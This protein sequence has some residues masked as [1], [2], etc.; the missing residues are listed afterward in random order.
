MI[1]KTIN[2]V[3]ISS[4]LIL[5]NAPIY[6]QAVYHHVQHTGIYEFLD[7]MGTLHLID[8]HTAIKPYTRKTIAEKLAV[9]NDKKDSLNARQQ[10]ELAFYLKDFNKELK[11]GKNFNKRIDLFYY[12]DSLFTFSVNPIL[13]SKAYYNANKLV[14]HWWNGAEAFAY[15]DDHWGF[16]ASLRD[17]H[18]SEQLYRKQD[19]LSKQIGG[20]NYKN[21]DLGK[22]FEEMRGGVTYAWKWGTLG[23]VKDQFVWGN[24]YNGSN[25]FSGTTPSF[26]HIKLHLTPAKWF[27]FRYVHAWLISESLDSL[28]SYYF[29]TGPEI[30]YRGIYY[31]KYMAANMFT[32][33]PINGLNLS[34]G[35]SIIYSD[36][37][38]HPAY[39]V[40]IFFYKAVDHTLNAGTDNMNSQMFFDISTRNV[41]H[42]HLYS[43]LFID[44]ISINRM[45]IDSSHSNFIS[46]KA[47][48]HITGLLPNTFFTVEY[49]KTNPLTYKHYIETLT[50]ESNRFNMG[51]YLTDNARE[52]Y[53]DASWKP[54]NTLKI[55]TFYSAAIKGTNYDRKTS[56]RDRWGLPFINETKWKNNTIGLSTRYEIIN[57]AYISAAFTRSIISGE[58]LNQYTPECF[59]GIKNTVSLGLNYGF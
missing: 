12:K 46:I 4:L 14:Y 51:H 56:A 24:N 16:Y 45:F 25:I 47:G 41:E 20:A 52:L 23:L 42:L 28:R 5:I 49:T 30:R 39:L 32:F 44:E 13:G 50:F 54:F 58:A 18:I 34:V 7:E 33:T 37:G 40:P 26:P 8:L 59:Q 19:H 43:S 29:T 22:D 36:I 3:L 6:S 48:A 2:T 31:P 55:S 27:T 1:K 10:K 9:L 53:I 15:I 11:P 17:N 38:V 35:N 57:G 21:T